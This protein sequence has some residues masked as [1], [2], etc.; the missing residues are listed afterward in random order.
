LTTSYYWNRP[1][2][3]T[4]WI[5]PC[6]GPLSAMFSTLAETFGLQLNFLQ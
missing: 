1:P 4:G 5:R 2:D 6:S 3:L